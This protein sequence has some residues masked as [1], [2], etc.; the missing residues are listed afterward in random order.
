M[1]NAA[2]IFCLIMIIFNSPN[3]VVGQWVQ[4]NGP[5]G[6]SVLCFTSMDEDLF[7]GTDGGV[8]HST[9]N[10]DSWN[11][12]DDGMWNPT[13]LSLATLGSEL[14]AAT[15]GGGVFRSTNKGTTWSP[16]NNGLGGS[17]SSLAVIG[18]FLFAGEFSTSGGVFRSDN[19]GSSW[20]RVGTITDQI[21]TLAVIDTILF[22]QTRQTGVYRSTDYGTSWIPVNTGLPIDT[23][24]CLLAPFDTILYAG[25]SIGLYCSTDYGDNWTEVDMVTNDMVFNSASI[26]TTLFIGTGNGGIYSTDDGTNWKTVTTSLYHNCLY[27]HG[28]DLFAGT[29]RGVYR[30]EDL[31]ETWTEGFAG[32][33]STSVR[34]MM[35]WG[36][37]LYAV[38]LSG[39][40]RSNDGGI[41]WTSFGPGGHSIAIDE[42]H[43]YIGSSGH[44]VCS[45]DNGVNWEWVPVAPGLFVRAVALHG[46]DLF[47]GMDGEGAGVYRITYNAPGWWTIT[48]TTL[49]DIAIRS[50]LVKDANIFAGTDNGIFL[51]ENNG[52]SWTQLNNGLPDSPVMALAAGDTFIFAG[53]QN[54]GIFRS[55]DN[56]KNWTPVNTGLTWMEVISFAVSEDTVFAGTWRGGVFLSVNNGDIWRPVN[57][58]L[59]DFGSDASTVIHALAIQNP[60]IYAGTRGAGAWQRLLSEMNIAVAV[61]SPNGGEQWKAGSTEFVT[62]TSSNIQNVKIEYSTNSGSSW[63]PI[64]NSTAA[65]PAGYPWLIPVVASENCLVRISDILDDYVN[66]VS[67]NLFTIYQP[68][69]TLISPNGGENWKAG[70][71]DTIK[72][73]SDNIEN[74]KIEYSVNGGMEWHLIVNTIASS[75]SAYPWTIPDTLSTNCLVRV[76]DVLDA[77]T[78]DISDNLFTIYRPSLL[79]L[80]PDGKERWKAGSTQTIKWISDHID[81]I[82][83][84]YSLDG[85]TDWNTVVNSV[86]AIPSTYL[87][88][89][90][91]TQ[92][93][94]CLVKISD[95]LDA[96]IKDVSDAL[97]TI[98]RPSLVLTS[99]NGSEKWKSGTIDTIKWVSNYILNIRIDYSADGGDKWSPVVDAIPAADSVYHWT[100]PDTVSTICM[101]RISDVSDSSVYDV[102]DTCFA[103]ET[104]PAGILSAGNGIPREYRLLQNYP[105]PFNPQT[106][107]KFA[108]PEPE[109]VKI[110]V[111]NLL[112][113]KIC[114]LINKAMPAGYHEVG[115]NGQYL[116]SGI[117]LYRMEAGAFQAVRK[118]ML[119]R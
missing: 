70:S 25:T 40:F 28:S 93:T 14:F 107:I 54:A 44:V 64:V 33:I 95:V 2:G 56:G 21:G 119:L 46:T 36:D 7:I 101:V 22:A 94:S 3:P 38:T 53:T 108:L 34:A 67:D 6:A 59:V 96:G 66:D 69:L 13:V 60:Y 104:V 77:K 110:E 71:T 16:A 73:I 50:L 15:H 10:G 52:T 82:K 24:I 55:P 118:M 23:T 57:S 117:Y 114:T 12:V 102:S 62:W 8:Y 100:I 76:S 41:S 30:S 116:A 72:W 37:Y 115:F 17:T 90:P 5:N 91:D 105:N 88:M 18:S 19:L 1:K 39:T 43:F 87:W 63:N 31:G 74:I 86:A 61:T 4:T 26:G 42:H 20:T 89:L 78:N 92:S 84:E 81:S 45:T 51:S 48:Q 83:I 75:P 80:E 99:P 35:T 79:L 85:G 29:S 9:D 113:R 106:Q 47:A 98:Y 11:L 112:G 111:Y 27:A 58:G 103:I 49:R 65:V 97:F 109:F 32:L 68:S